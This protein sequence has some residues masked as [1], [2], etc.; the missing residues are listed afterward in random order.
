[1]CSGGQKW[2]I[3][4]RKMGLRPPLGRDLCSRGLLRRNKS[5]LT[6]ITDSYPGTY[7][8][9]QMWHP[10]LKCEKIEKN[11]ILNRHLI[12]LR[13]KKRTKT[14]EWKKNKSIRKTHNSKYSRLIVPYE[15]NRP[16][17][18]NMQVYYF[19]ISQSKKT[20]TA[21]RSC[22]IRGCF[23]ISLAA[24]KRSNDKTDASRRPNKTTIKWL[25]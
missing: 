17:F 24:L 5:T 4:F 14:K 23:F 15:S 20:I 13:E 6:P 25:R 7:P 9:Y 3:P 19:S 16:Y 12:R 1:M 22:L 18:Y 21:W 8:R 10:L 11:I 2:L